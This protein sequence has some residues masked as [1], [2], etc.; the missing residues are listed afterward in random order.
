M[1][2]ALWGKQVNIILILTGS[3]CSLWS[4][5]EENVRSGTHNISRAIIVYGGLDALQHFDFKV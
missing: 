4:R 2:R 3:Q 5:T 1:L